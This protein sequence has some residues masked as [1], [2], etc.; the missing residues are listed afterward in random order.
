MPLPPTPSL[1]SLSRGLGSCGLSS[2]LV[3]AHLEP[4]CTAAQLS[5]NMTKRR[6]CRECR[7]RKGMSRVPFMQ[8]GDPVQRV[9]VE[10]PQ[11]SL[12]SRT[13]L[14]P[15]A[16][17]HLACS[18]VRWR[19]W[20]TTAPHFSQVHRPGRCDAVRRMRAPRH[21]L[22]GARLDDQHALRDLVRLSLASP[23]FP[24][25]LFRISAGNIC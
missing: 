15:C 22:R 14:G 9:D 3:F 19:S 8:C 18:V 24:H 1:L 21:P 2:A 4:L 13:A 17:V 11:R 16:S 20:L 6:A 12:L 7:H 10:L 25:S 23:S 5:N